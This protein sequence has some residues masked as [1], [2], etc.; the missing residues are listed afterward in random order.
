MKINLPFSGKSCSKS[1]DVPSDSLTL[2]LP[3][4]SNWIRWIGRE[5]FYLATRSAERIKVERSLNTR[6]FN[7]CF[8]IFTSW[9]AERRIQQHFHPTLQQSWTWGQIDGFYM[10]IWSPGSPHCLL[11]NS[12][13]IV[14]IRQVIIPLIY[15]LSFQVFNNHLNCNSPWNAPDWPSQRRPNLPKWLFGRPPS[16]TSFASVKLTAV[17]AWEVRDPALTVQPTRQTWFQGC[18]FATWHKILS[19]VCRNMIKCVPFPPVVGHHFPI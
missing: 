15:A 1:R 12:P 2:H 4:K 16:P 9:R 5:A 3:S 13:F 14:N 6:S 18:I 7:T 8:T 11:F 19:L 17:P 10:D